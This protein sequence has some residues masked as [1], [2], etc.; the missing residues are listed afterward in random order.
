MGLRDLVEFLRQNKT[1]YAEYLDSEHW[2]NTR[3]RFWRS[4]LH[5]GVCYVCGGKDSLQVHHKSYKRLGAEP[6]IHLCLLCDGCHKATHELDRNRGKGC[7][8][9]AARR[10]RRNLKRI[11]RDSQMLE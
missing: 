8:W 4:K 9:G 7:L 6:L 1:T 5:N 3:Q 2:R 11:D 10:L